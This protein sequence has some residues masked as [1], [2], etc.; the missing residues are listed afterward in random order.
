M[1][2]SLKITGLRET[3]R[4]LAELPKATG[5]NVLRRVGKRALEPMRAKA[6]NLAPVDR[7]D[8]ANQVVI[9]EKR[10]RR[11]PKQRGPKSG[12]EIAMGP[13]AGHGVLQYAGL[14]EF[15]TVDNPPR[16]YM[17]PAFNSEAQGALDSVTTELLGEIEKS[18]KR[19]A[20]KR[21]KG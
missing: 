1:G 21:S 15:G 20:R 16:P 2:K 9:S 6:E 13:A 10:T 19:L 8:L 5:K 17:R 12:V 14:V 3:E 18:A 11:V 4:A 7:G